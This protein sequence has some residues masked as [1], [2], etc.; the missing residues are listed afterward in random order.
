VAQTGSDSPAFSPVAIAPTYNNAGTL[1][2]V[3]DR[4]MALGLPLIVVNDGSTDR[5]VE[6]LGGWAAAHGQLA[7]IAAHPANRGKAA[8]MMT[9]FRLAAERGYSHAVTIDT[10]GQLDP[11]QIPELLAVA[12]ESP[13]SL[14][15]GF[16]DDSSPD[17]PP[18][19]R[20]GRR[21]SNFAIRLEC[22]EHVQDSQCG[23]RVY[24]LPLALGVRCRADRFGF[25]TEIITKAA[26]AGCS[27]R[28]VPVN[29]RYLSGGRQVTHF[30]VQRDTARHLVLHARLI[31]RALWPWP[32]ERL[33]AAASADA[34]LSWRELI[35]W[36]SPLELWRQMRRRPQD[37]P[38]LAAGVALGVFIAN[39]PIYGLQTL[40][41]VYLARRLHLHP[42][43]VVVGSHFSTPPVGPALVVAAIWLGHLL[44]FGEPITAASLDVARNGLAPVAGRLLLEWTVGG[45]LLGLA[46]SLISFAAVL[47]LMR[48]IR[49]PTPPPDEK[50]GEL[51]EPEK[52]A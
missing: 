35:R 1:I 13:Q 14:V 7:T 2:A 28:E 27:I 45:V 37:R 29:C 5:T 19:S 22:G 4:V 26:W 46:F 50:G 38:A 30:N 42:M 49:T 9:G 41:S 52:P 44:L 48:L 8:A 39:L 11:E 21:L 10:D 6:L 34:G 51:V 16:R 3:L 24:P 23:L 33:F 20:T 32:H 47:L 17:Y 18:R 40:T 31:A 36:A 43:A 12:R 15:L 25:E